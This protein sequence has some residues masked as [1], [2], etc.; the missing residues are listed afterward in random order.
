MMGANF[1]DFAFI[2][3]LFDK[4]LKTQVI[5]RKIEKLYFIKIKNLCVSEDTQREKAICIVWGKLFS[6][7]VCDKGHTYRTYKQLLQLSKK[8]QIQ[9]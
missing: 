7:H 9:L 5:N 6:N 3:D 8:T 1:H 2:N 4:T